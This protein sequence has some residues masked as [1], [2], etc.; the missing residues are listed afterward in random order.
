MSEG[1]WKQKTKTFKIGRVSLYAEAS[2]AG[3]IYH[4]G[5]SLN[6]DTP[7]AASICPLQHSVDT[8]NTTS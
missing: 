4:L 2:L 6:A 8:T 1:R 3:E 5:H 7:R